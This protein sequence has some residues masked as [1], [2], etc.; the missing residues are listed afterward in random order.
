[1]DREA[2]LNDIIKRDYQDT[3]RKTAP[4]KAA[5]DAHIIDTTQLTLE[6]SVEAVMKCIREGMS[7]K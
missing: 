5:E 6:E 2:I 1:M 4:L 3:H 7:G